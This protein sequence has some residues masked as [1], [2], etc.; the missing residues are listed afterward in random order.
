MIAMKR[1]LSVY[2]LSV[3]LGLLGAGGMGG[4]ALLILRPDGSLLGMEAGWLDGSPFSSYLL[5]GVLLLIAGGLLPL[6]ALVGVLW[7]PSWRWAEGLNIYRTYHWGW[8]FSL[9][10]GIAAIIWIAVQQVV[11][12]YFI[13]QPVISVGGAVILILTLLPASMNYQRKTGL[14]SYR[15]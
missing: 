10:S 2:G 15:R 1:P 5:P 14:P 9:Y 4:A 6:I 11:A 13:L 8:A 3:M 12:R 7:Q